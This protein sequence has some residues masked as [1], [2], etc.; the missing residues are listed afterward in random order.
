[1]SRNMW[2]T[3]IKELTH[4]SGKVRHSL[5]FGPKP[6]GTRM[7]SCQ[8][9]DH[10]KQVSGKGLVNDKLKDR[11]GIKKWDMWLGINIKVETRIKDQS[12]Q[13]TYEEK[14]KSNT[15]RK[16][17]LWSPLLPGSPSIVSLKA[18]ADNCRSESNPV[19]LRGKERKNNQ[20]NRGKIW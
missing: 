1:M 2:T 13:R 3:R 5:W 8:G 17:F 18:D 14:S 6:G 15:D 16:L 9:C 7:S 11:Q 12:R 10:P 20:K 4:F 19:K